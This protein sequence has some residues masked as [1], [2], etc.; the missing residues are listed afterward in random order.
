VEDVGCQGGPGRYGVGV[1]D[2][3]GAGEFVVAEHVEGAVDGRLVGFDGEALGG[4]ALP[5]GVGCV[6]GEDA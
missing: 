4:E 2:A 6:G 5:G 1:G 3:F